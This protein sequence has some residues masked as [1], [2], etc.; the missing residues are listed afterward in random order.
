MDSN[1]PTNKFILRETFVEQ[2]MEF[3]LF[4]TNFQRKKLHNKSLK[5]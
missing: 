3:Q 1:G 2:P 5:F 4:A